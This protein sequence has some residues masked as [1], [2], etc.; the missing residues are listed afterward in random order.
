MVSVK[1]AIPTSNIFNGVQNVD[2][3]CSSV[4][5]NEGD[6]GVNNVVNV[7]PVMKNKNQIPANLL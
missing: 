2:T 6:S 4:F 1:N 7:I 3:I 5:M